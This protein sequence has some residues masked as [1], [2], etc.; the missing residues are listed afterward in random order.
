MGPDLTGE[1]NT[2]TAF[3]VLKNATAQKTNAA[4]SEGQRDVHMA[5]DAGA[6][7]LDQAKTMVESIVTSAQDYLHGSTDS[8]SSAGPAT[9]SRTGGDVISS[10]QTSASSAVGTAQQYLASA[11]AAAQPQVDKARET[12]EGYLGMHSGTSP[13]NA[14]TPPGSTT[15]PTTGVPLSG[16]A[17]SLLDDRE[18]NLCVKI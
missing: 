11:Q 1:S 12:A 3:D 10:L 2:S 4:A 17:N 9:S 13:S 8:R 6:S 18:G 16:A 7:Y 14:V 5:K 15:R